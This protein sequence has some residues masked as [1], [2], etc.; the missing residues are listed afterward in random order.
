MVIPVSFTLFVLVFARGAPRWVLR[1]RTLFSVLVAGLLV[2]GFLSLRSLPVELLPNHASQIITVSVLV[3]GGL[4]P[5]EVEERLS[6]PLESALEGLPHLEAVSSVAKYGRCVVGLTFDSK[7][8]MP[9]MT[10]AVHERIEQ[11]ADQLPPETE[12]P[13]I[14]HYEDSDAPVYVAALTSDSSSPEEIRSWA[15]RHVRERLLRV[16]GVANV[17]LAGGREKKVIVSLDQS[18]MA[19]YGLSV[20]RVTSLLSKRNLAVK[21]GSGETGERNLSVRLDALFPRVEDIRNVRVGRDLSRETIRLGQVATVEE[22]PLEPEGFSR[23]NGRPA[24]SIYVQKESSANTLTVAR[25]VQRCLREVWGGLPAG[26]RKNVQSV[27]I[28]D[29]AA[30]V[31]S[32]I[33]SMRISVLFGVLLIVLVLSVIH[34]A[35]RHLRWGGISLL[36]GTVF[37]LCGRALF[38]WESVAIEILLGV[39]LVVVFASGIRFRSLRPALLV[40]G[41]IPLSLLLSLILLKSAGA[42]L[43]AMTLFGLALGAGLLVDNAIVVFERIR[44]RWEGAEVGSRSESVAPAAESAAGPL[45]ASTVTTLVV[46]LPFLFLPPDVTGFY[47]DLGLAVTASLVSSLIVSLTVIP[48]LAPVVLDET[49]RSGKEHDPLAPVVGSVVGRLLSS[50]RRGWGHLLGFLQR[51]P[52]LRTASQFVGVCIV[53]VSSLFALGQPVEGR[54]V[55]SLFMGVVCLVGSAWIV[56]RRSLRILFGRYRGVFLWGMLILSLGG[57]SLLAWGTERDSQP[58]GE[59]DEFIVFLECSGG[60]KMARTDL[61]VREVERKMTRSAVLS[62]LVRTVVSRVEGSG[63]RLYVTLKPRKQR[64]LGLDEAVELFRR[65]LRGVG[66]NIDEESF[67]HFSIPGAGGDDIGVKVYG[68]DYAVLEDLSQQV[69]EGLG[70]I[71]GLRDVKMRYRPPRPEVE[72]RLDPEKLVCYGVTAEHVSETVHGAIRGLRATVFHSSRDQTDVVVRLRNADRADVSVLKDVRI[73][74]GKG[75][76]VR[77]GELA[78]FGVVRSP[79]EIVRAE[80]QRLIDVTASRSGVPSGR[81]LRRLKTVLGSIRFPL[82]YYAKEDEALTQETSRLGLLTLTV[83]GTVGLVLVVLVVFFESWK[84]P[85]VI[86]GSVP[87]GILGAAWGLSVFQLPLSPGTLVG[88]MVLGGVVVN[89]AILIKDR[90]A[91]NRSEGQ[92]FSSVELWCSAV[93]ERRRIVALTTGT[94]VMGFLPMLFDWSEGGD[95][96]RSLAVTM[97]FGLIAGAVLTLLVIPCLMISL[98]SR[99]R[100]DPS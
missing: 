26:W 85:W 92:R 65:E 5:L 60:L 13:V 40:G 17:E 22:S 1:R 19:A 95:V 74:L 14:A 39:V 8:D 35:S 75:G 18:R 3:R 100:R 81:V 51:G 36:A 41:V 46:F 62:P 49:G 88:L 21:V 52:C 55:F 7:A 9:R 12:K 71:R 24:I 77:L 83:L 20:Q 37:L 50:G 64:S 4:A 45:L 30:L 76:S 33:R 53:M 38:Q 79:H 80:K 15:D 58:T 68:P 72:V 31:R 67:L 91:Q 23:L 6:K 90:F 93:S 73:P 66:R 2:G 63:A 89:N 16:P 57:G 96:W 82:D 99:G 27:V 48:C 87:L 98:E 59:P 42:T 47:S 70:R 97:V 11:I 84:E 94:T 56:D 28:V 32:S 25:S 61:I 69:A 86:L 10:V 34:T 29:Q 43:N 78:V 44:E 54:L